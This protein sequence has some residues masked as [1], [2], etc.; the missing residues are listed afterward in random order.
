MGK[1]R[2]GNQKN[3]LEVTMCVLQKFF[4]VCVRRDLHDQLAGDS[5]RFGCLASPDSA[6]HVF[7]D[8]GNPM[9]KIS[10]REEPTVVTAKRE[11][12]TGV[13]AHGDNG[14]QYPRSPGGR[15]GMSGSV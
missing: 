3:T 12:L 13:R 5:T 10:T 14:R 7:D 1:I 6:V 8:P 11:R 15:G 4:R 9:A 2:S